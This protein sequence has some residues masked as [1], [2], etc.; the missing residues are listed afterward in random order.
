MSSDNEQLMG[1][2]LDEA[3]RLK[4]KHGKSMQDICVVLVSLLC[5]SLRLCKM[6]AEEAK[7]FLDSVSDSYADGLKTIKFED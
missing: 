3:N 7:A 1:D 6:S 4:K 5:E 2:L